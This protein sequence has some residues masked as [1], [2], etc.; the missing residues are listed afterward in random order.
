MNHNR[1]PDFGLYIV[2]TEPVLG[3]EVFTELC[4]REAVPMLQ[5]RD[6]HLSD[7][8]LLALMQRLKAITKGSGTRLII[9]DRV[10]LALL[11]DMDGL[12]L[13]PDDLPWQTV[14]SML[15]ADKLIGVSTHSIQEAQT[16]IN[17]YN[18]GLF[19]GRPN[20]M[21][22]GPVYPTP[23][24]AK[25]DAA[26]GLDALRAIV[27]LAPIP[28]VAIGG[29]FPSQVQGILATGAKNIAMIRHF[30]LCKEASELRDKITRI[31]EILKGV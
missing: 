14:A 18:S 19:Q 3:Y 29:I 28:L 23:A 31:K 25:P 11:G 8:A 2:M 30:T 26:L 24:K 10:D 27:A 20:Y 21:S 15:P 12:H 7:R 9:N 22:L 16:L 17:Q 5:L 6:K 13:G 1:M 4:T